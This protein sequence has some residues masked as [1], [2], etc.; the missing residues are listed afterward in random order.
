V[1]E[2]EGEGGRE[3]ERERGIPKQNVED[4][5]KKFAVATDDMMRGPR[6]ISFD[7]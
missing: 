5:I 6:Y 7:T 2:T 3:R 1:C 4:E